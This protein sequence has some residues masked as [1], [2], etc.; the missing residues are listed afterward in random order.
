MN[1]RPA[2]PSR[3]HTFRRHWD[4]CRPWASRHPLEGREVWLERKLLEEKVARLIELD[5]L[6]DDG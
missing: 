4:G 5:M 3:Y 6:R 2:G 1:H